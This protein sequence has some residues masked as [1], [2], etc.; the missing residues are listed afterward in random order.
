MALVHSGGLIAA[1]GLGAG[2]LSGGVKGALIGFAC[3]GA[4]FSTIFPI[5]CSAA[6]RKAGVNAQ[7]ASPPS[8]RSAIWDSWPVR[9]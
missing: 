7:A 6:G 9:H 2:L 3:A 4:G 1:A 5:A 8:Q